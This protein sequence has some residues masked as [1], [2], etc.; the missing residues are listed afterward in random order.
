MTR[1]VG[2]SKAGRRIVV[3]AVLS[4]AGLALALAGWWWT[5]RAPPPGYP[6][7]P[8][9]LGLRLSFD[10]EFS[11]DQLDRDRWRTS[12]FGEPGREAPVQQRTLP[13]N[14]EQQLYMDPDFLGLGIRP[15][16]VRNG[17]LTIEARPL[18]AEAL[19]RVRARIARLTPEQRR[20]GPI[21]KVRYSS[22]IIT[23]R[24]SFSQTY[25]YFEV[26]ARLPAGRGLWSAFWML[27]E[28]D[29]WPPE[30]DVME[31]LGHEPSTAYTTVHSRAGAGPAGKN[32]VFDPDGFHRYGA[33]WLPDRI[34]FYLDGRK[35]FAGP[36][37]PDAHR[38]MH[39]LI[40]LAV[41]GYWPGSPDSSTRFPARMT[42]DY[43]RAWAL[44]GRWSDAAA[45][46]GQRTR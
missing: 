34:E 31:V 3:A 11:G 37:P 32:R 5:D 17:M 14:G 7:P 19:R 9:G 22:G 29:S 26:R 46:R 40:N 41:G 27:P 30:I 4:F 25:G 6:G 23:T 1:H 43:V 33:L 2:N 44:P 36:T 10:E 28:D 38:P 39:M 15:L 18:P 12:F 20:Y 24:R 16:A 21:E 45:Q 13:S 42:V 8:P 35:V